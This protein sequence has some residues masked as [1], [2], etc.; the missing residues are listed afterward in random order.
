MV[1][2]PFTLLLGS[3]GHWPPEWQSA[4][5]RYA[6]WAACAMA[7]FVIALALLRNRRY[8]ARRVLGE[9]DIVAVRAALA[10]A[11]SRT[12]GEIV[13]VVVERSDAHPDSRWLVALG[14]LLL[15][16]ALLGP[17]LPWE[18]PTLLLCQVGLGAVGWLAAFAL[19]DLQRMLISERRATHVAQ[20]QAAQEFFR[21]GLHRTREATGVLLFVSLLEHRVIVLGDAGIHARVGDSHWT[22]TTHAVLEGIAKGSLRDGLIAG[23]ER[24]GAVL[25]EHFPGR[26]D[27]RNELADRLVVR[28]Q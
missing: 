5:A 1:S 4:F 2:P 20:E 17:H 18:A 24:C 26:P 7:V 27:D 23:I 25:A 28:R 3:Q 19:P 22:G 11:E 6:P 14:A 9:S 16:S 13:S 10:Q 15:G 12:T 8:L 21:Q